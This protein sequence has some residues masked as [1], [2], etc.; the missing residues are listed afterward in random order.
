MEQGK[1]PGSMMSRCSTRKALLRKKGK[2]EGRCVT[3]KPCTFPVI[4]LDSV[5]G[6]KPYHL[7]ILFLEFSLFGLSFP[8]AFTLLSQKLISAI[9]AAIMSAL[10]FP[11]ISPAWFDLPLP[12]PSPCH[13]S[14]SSAVFFF[15]FLPCHL[16]FRWPH[17]DVWSQH[18]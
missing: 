11:I 4:H 10:K 5:N 1:A 6:L 2:K 12:V 15:F 16:I 13:L 8:S 3:C 7:K 17:L 18:R 14:W 9:Q